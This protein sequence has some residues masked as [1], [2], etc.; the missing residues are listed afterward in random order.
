MLRPFFD[1]LVQLITRTSTDPAARRPQGDGAALA[2]EE[3]ATAPA[4]R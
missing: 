2:T 3:R 4:R 1:S